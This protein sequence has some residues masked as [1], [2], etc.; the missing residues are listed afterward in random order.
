M[1]MEAFSQTASTVTDYQLHKLHPEVRMGRARSSRSSLSSSKRP[2]WLPCQRDQPLLTQPLNV[3]F[4][5]LHKSQD[6]FLALA[7]ELHER[8]STQGRL[9]AKTYLF[10][11]DFIPG[12]LSGPYAHI[13]GN[14]LLR[15]LMS[16]PGEISL[17]RHKVAKEAE[18]AF[19]ELG[20]WMQ[21]GA[22]WKQASK[23][24]RSEGLARA[25]GL[26]SPAAMLAL[27]IIAYPDSKFKDKI[28]SLRIDWMVERRSSLCVKEG[29]WNGLEAANL[30]DVFLPETSHQAEESKLS[31][32]YDRLFGQDF[33]QYRADLRPCLPTWAQHL[34][35]EGSP[36][37]SD[38]DAVEDLASDSDNDAQED[39]KSNG[40]GHSDRAASTLASDDTPPVEELRHL[41]LSRQKAARSLSPLEAWVMGKVF[42]D[43]NQGYAAWCNFWAQRMNNTDSYE[44]QLLVRSLFLQSLQRVQA[45]A[46]S[47]AFQGFTEAYMLLDQ[48]GAESF[49][50]PEDVGNDGDDRSLQDA[51]PYTTWTDIYSRFLQL[52]QVVHEESQTE[53]TDRLAERLR[54]Q[55]CTFFHQLSTDPLRSDHLKNVL[56]LD[57]L[58]FQVLVEMMESDK[59]AAPVDALLDTQWIVRLKL[60]NWQQRSL[61]A[62]A[63]RASVL[64]DFQRKLFQQEPLPGQSEFVDYSQV[65]PL[66]LRRADTQSLDATGNRILRQLFGELE[67]PADER[68]APLVS[69]IESL[70]ITPPH[71]STSLDIAEKG[72]GTQ[73]RSRTPVPTSSR[74]KSTEIPMPVVQAPNPNGLF[75]KAAGRAFVNRTSAST[76]AQITAPAHSRVSSSVADAR[77]DGSPTPGSKTGLFAK[78]AGRVCKRAHSPDHTQSS[79][80]PRLSDMTEDDFRLMLRDEIQIELAA[81]R[82]QFKA[83]FNDGKVRFEASLKSDLAADRASVVADLRAEHAEASIRVTADLKTELAAERQYQR[84]DA[85]LAATAATERFNG[86]RSDLTE[87]FDWLRASY[88]EIKSSSETTCKSTSNLDQRVAD[89]QEEMIAISSQIGLVAGKLDEFT[90]LGPPKIIGED[91]F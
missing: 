7:Y 84:T 32:D 50:V 72:S 87:R 67:T 66:P 58:A 65:L 62:G 82:E 21:K 33:Q 51:V 34:S 53:G 83:D 54:N 63:N 40:T 64:T 15:I 88:D 30:Q 91:G 77:A 49:M 61:L 71:S 52:V 5:K 23:V 75:T 56:A 24:A 14:E 18:S 78:A 37:L 85:A 20:R 27:L 38:M 26:F 81:E 19:A 43:N 11:R 8:D 80:V 12:G 13:S 4:I 76:S 16:H 46:Q 6:W 17:S 42:D 29:Y 47:E 31:L 74:S 41:L 70:A 9:L 45:I 69:P 44:E 86:L 25:P 48:A 57:R 39:G 35:L 89:M 55:Q 10:L 36:D 68:G 2:D 22:N 28:A 3:R 1:A 79:K 60:T 90:S 73:S 59:Q